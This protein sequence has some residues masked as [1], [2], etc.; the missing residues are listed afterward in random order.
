[1]QKINKVEVKPYSDEYVKLHEEFSKKFWPNKKRRRIEIYNRWKF[2]GPDK[3]NVDGLLLA[4][5]D[6]KIVGQI[7]LLPVKLKSG[8]NIYN[9]QWA[10]DLMV[11]LN[12]R[13]MGIG[14]KLFETAMLRDNIITLGNNPSAK[15]GKVMEKIGFKHLK[16]GRTMIF[17]L[18]SEQVLKW[19]VPEKVRGIIPMISK[20]VQPYFSLKVNKFKKRNTD[21]ETCEWEEVSDL[22]NERQNK[23]SYP[24]I[25]HDKKFLDW[26][27]NGLENFSEKIKAIRSPD[28][29]YALY[30]PFADYLDVYDWYCQSFDVLEK[31][32]SAVIL[33]ALKAKIS[34]IQIVA[35]NEEE[36]TWLKKLGFIRTR[37]KERVLHFSKDKLIDNEEKFYFALFDTDRNL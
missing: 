36:E 35:N 20:I 5:Y 37:S 32:F 17:P 9:A 31:M 33:M 13:S 30:S 3:G 25:L 21:F 18:K 16:S 29:A 34:M 23:L 14:S 28:S 8:K 1:M 4:L 6:N 26:R 10:C 22:I 7:G 12:Y 15:A 24:Q 19:A 27:A 2:R 11:D